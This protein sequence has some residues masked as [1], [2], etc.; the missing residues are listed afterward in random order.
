VRKH[1]YLRSKLSLTCNK[2]IP[3][4][5]GPV[6]AATIAPPPEGGI[7]QQGQG[8]FMKKFKMAA[9]A[10]ALTL[11]SFGAMAQSAY[12]SGGVGLGDVDAC[13]GATNCDTSSTAFKFVGGYEF[14]NRFAFEIG[15]IDFGKA[16]GSGGG[17]SADIKVFGPTIGMAFNAPLSQDAGM[18]FRLGVANLKTKIE[19]SLA[20]FGSGSASET[21][22]VPYFGVGFNYAVAQNVLIEAG[23]DFS[24]GEF[25]GEKADVR[26]ITFGVRLKF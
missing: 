3:D 24:R 22:T 16:S 8:F 21:N 11:L 20:G 7:N 2:P 12:V 6:A 1:R 25:D 14:A 15:Y 17:L 10:S 5:D 4:C 26:A 18:N 23:A 13:E 19:A 9:V